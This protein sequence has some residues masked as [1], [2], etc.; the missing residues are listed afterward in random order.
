MNIVS[1]PFMCLTHEID[2]FGISRLEPFRRKSMANRSFFIPSICFD[3]VSCGLYKYQIQSDPLPPN[4][5]IIVFIFAT[6]AKNIDETGDFST[7]L[8]VL[9]TLFT[10]RLNSLRFFV[11]IMSIT[12]KSIK[13]NRRETEKYEKLFF[14]LSSEKWTDLRNVKERYVGQQ[15]R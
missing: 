3:F 2:V 14:Y 11:S 12:W 10:Q 1:H 13:T 9:S 7:F 8:A 5:W 4:P 6:N 15:F